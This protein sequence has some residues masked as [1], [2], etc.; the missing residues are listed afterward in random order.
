[1]KQSEKGQREIGIQTKSVMQAQRE[2]ESFRQTKA[3]C[4]GEKG[5]VRPGATFVVNGGMTKGEA[6]GCIC[7]A[8]LCRGASQGCVCTSGGGNGVAAGCKVGR[9]GVGGGGGAVSRGGV[10]TFSGVQ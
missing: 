10:R 2:R 7:A 4:E 6:R 3:E 1:M 9:A 5:T 8:P